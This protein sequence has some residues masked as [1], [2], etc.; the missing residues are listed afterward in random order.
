MALFLD[1]RSGQTVPSKLREVFPD[2]DTQV[3]A[4]CPI[5]VLDESDDD[6]TASVSSDESFHDALEEPP[7]PPR[8]VRLP[9]EVFEAIMRNL[10]ALDGEEACLKACSLVCKEWSLP[11]RRILLGGGLTVSSADAAKRLREI[12]DSHAELRPAVR[13]INLNGAMRDGLIA[14]YFRRAAALFRHT[15]NLRMLQLVHVGLSEMNRHRLYSAM[16]HL[17]LT[18]V[19]LYSSSWSVSHLGQTPGDY[20]DVREVLR[21]L[22]DWNQLNSLTLSGYSSY[23][24]LLLPTTIPAHAFPTY[25]L[26]SLHLLSCN[27]ADSIVLWLLGNSAKTLK[28]LNLCGCSGLTSEILAQVFE[29]LG[30]TLETLVLTLDVDDLAAVPGP[31]S[32]RS[33]VVETLVQLR[34]VSVST[35]SVF[36][37]DIVHTLVALPLVESISLCYPS[38]TY[39]IVKDDLA[40]LPPASKL[41]KLYLDAWETPDMW[42]ETERWDLAQLCEKRG[43]EL[44]L[45]GL[46]KADIE[47]EWYGEDFSEDWRILERLV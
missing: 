21:L 8:P 23:P 44:V 16:R 39:A 45:N 42:T 41:E 29:V 30:P 43:V 25:R 18:H 2:L 37:E 31:Q 19:I 22:C 28:Q 34:V 17:P 46:V 33:E 38:F 11:A 24:R 4:G 15:P 26:E 9:E 32:V 3:P 20:A 36:P 6:A 14:P 27:L 35:D 1:R 10:E 13:S 12:L 7:P 40:S 5:Y 47:E